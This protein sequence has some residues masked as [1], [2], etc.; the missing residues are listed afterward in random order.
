MA[1]KSVME[2]AIPTTSPTAT[3]TAVRRAPVVQ[4]TLP[5]GL[6]VLLRESHDAPIASFWVWYRVGSRNEVPG[7]TGISHWVEHMQFKGTPSLAKGQIFRDV[8]RNGGILNA[9]TSHDWT[10]YFETLPSDRLDL[11]LAIESD[12]MVNSLFDPDETES[13]RT[14]ILSERKGSENRPSYLLIEEVFG[15]AFR[16]HP[17]RHMVIGYESDLRSITRDD[18]YSHYRRYYVPNNA[19]ISAVGDFDAQEL[20]SRIEERFGGIPAGDPVPPVNIQEPE[21]LGERRVTIYRPAPASHLWIAYH[22][23]AATHPDT[24][25]LMV[26]DAVL[27]GAKG[28]GLAGGGAMGRSARLY[29]A[30]VASGFARAAGS[31][32]GLSLDPYLM[33][34]GATALPGVDPQRI[35]AVMDEEIERIREE[36][37]T[38]EELARVRKQLTA[39]YVYSSAGVTNQAFWLGQMEI[40]DE[41]SRAD[42]LVDELKAVTAEDIR[43]VAQTYLRREN[44]TVG[45][46]HPEESETQR[47]FPAVD[48]PDLAAAADA[49]AES[50][51][52]AD[53]DVA[54]IFGHDD[55]ATA[56]RRES[57]GL[58]TVA[59]GAVGEASRG[60]RGGAAT[61]LRPF[62]RQELP[63][64]IV[65]LGQPRPD[66]PAVVVR[67]RLA[68]GSLNETAEQAGVAYFTARMLQR[69]QLGR[70]Y[71]QFT[72]I[73][74]NLGA[75]I[76][77]DAGRMHVDLSIR[78]LREDLPTML[79]LAADV[80]RRPDF[81]ED[82]IE[83]V[84][85]EILA[86]IRES[87]DNTGI[88]A[89]RA[90]LH[91]L[92]PEGHPYRQRVTGEPEDVKKITRDDL[93]R[94]HAAHYGPGTMTAAVVGGIPNLD[95]AAELISARFSDWDVRVTAPE[96]PEPAT[97]PERTTRDDR[98]IAGKS[99][100]NIAIGYP[101]LHRAH[102]DYY[103]LEV[104]TVILGQL[105]LSGRLGAEVRDRQGLAYGVSSDVDAG[106]KSGIW[107][108]NAGVAP[109]NVDRA[110]EAIVGEIRRIRSEAVE[111]EELSDAQS[112]LTG[113][114]PL[115]LES[116]GGVANLLL[117]IEYYD[118]GLD[119]LER[120]P[121]IINGLT[122][123]QLLEAVRTHLDPDRLAIGT[124]GPERT[125]V[126]AAR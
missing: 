120:Y 107:E 95:Y 125:S 105:G 58:G 51:L 12:R 126:G 43:R 84:R 74:D 48:V 91:I 18:L 103:A 79:D 113:V 11:S 90:M 33:L 22:V 24:A 57:L 27:S 41:F 10:A 99:Q 72:E 29:R 82:E 32:T 46:L 20:L 16:A 6:Q 122:R 101:T 56:I 26:M 102:P 109:E 60:S 15:T 93:V 114:L 5:N 52:E 55:P 9:L 73:S 115:A 23:P 49:G 30:L 31:D 112:Y 63:G 66:D 83:K 67:L 68:A 106:K 69:G 61:Q 123:E 42:T 34:F 62:E 86:A 121:E 1:K 8:S 25:P 85:Q 38:E 70:T 92:Y 3:S 110:I 39:Q 96:L 40:V 44:R 19:F 76:G 88:V 89:E 78:C 14:V 35:E 36:L 116:N 65:L 75:S 4:A 13:E 124:A 100:T 118:L 54:G 47:L 64:G 111:A 80:L 7:K 97:A 81:P 37:V 28:M 108:A 71:A 17:Y 104:A 98:I 53:A 59:A 117:S 45:W 87:D 50:D 77:V 94:F 2:T 21:Q 119:Y